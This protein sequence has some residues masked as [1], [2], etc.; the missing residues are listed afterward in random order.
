MFISK[1]RSK[2]VWIDLRIADIPLFWIDI[3][4]SSNSV[5][6]F[7]ELAGMKMNDHI[8][9]VEEFQPTDLLAS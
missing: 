4:S 8:E 9:G 5:G 2:V 3:P 1:D 6:F 7:T